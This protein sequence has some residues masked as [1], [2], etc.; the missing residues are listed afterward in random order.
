[1]LLGLMVGQ[2]RG[3]APTHHPSRT[4]LAGL[5]VLWAVVADLSVK[6]IAIHKPG[7]RL[8][9]VTAAG[10]ASLVGAWGVTSA[11]LETGMNR[12]PEER[13]GAWLSGHAT[14]EQ[15]LLRPRDYGYF[16]VKVMLPPGARFEMSRAI[17]PRKKD[18]KSPLRT[19]QALSAYLTRHG[20]TWIA[21]PLDTRLPRG[22]S[23]EKLYEADHWRVVRVT[24][25]GCLGDETPA[26]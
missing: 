3:G 17:D 18:S 10:V 12:G 4:L 2:L 14:H 11:A 8:L 13:L 25:D 24:Q 7:H 19:R 26:R 5:L 6:Q 15:V 20:A 23:G 21:L 16:A 22:C 1:M 9:L